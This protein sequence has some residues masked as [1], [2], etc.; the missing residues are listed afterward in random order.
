MTTQTSATKAGG[1]SALLA[2]LS[3]KAPPPEPVVKQD[4]LSVILSV[5]TNRAP[6]ADPGPA[7]QR[8][9]EKPLLP[10]AGAG[11]DATADATAASL[12]LCLLAPPLPLPPQ[13]PLL[14][15]AAAH[16]SLPVPSAPR[17]Q[18]A[19]Q[20]K[21]AKTDAAEKEPALATHLSP[22]D[23]APEKKPA[24]AA[25]EKAP[26]LAAQL[27]PANAAPEKKPAEAA[28]E[29]AP[30][31]AA[32]LSPA[33]AAP[34]KKPTQPV[35]DRALPLPARP[36]PAEVAAAKSAPSSGT[37]VALRSQRMN[38]MS[39]RDEIAGPTEQN[40]PGADLSAISGANAGG[41]SQD[42]AK[43][44]LAFSWQETASEEVAVAVLSAKA[45]GQ[46]APSTEAAPSEPPVSAPLDR[47][48][49]MI[50][51]QVVDFR[52]AGAQS[53]GVTLKVDAQTQLFLQLTT[54]N[55]QVR[56]S[57]RCDRGS[58][59]P[60]ESQWAQLQQSLARQNVQLLPLDGALR[61]GF[62]Q[63]PDNP[64]RHLASGS[65]NGPPAGAA[66]EPAQPR[67]QRGQNRSPKNWESWA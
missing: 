64:Q 12:L 36:P 10:P 61:P 27:S 50:F 6:K 23:T 35:T 48:E 40:L 38:Y 15:K 25:A 32:Q 13:L 66:V 42:R 59:S 31:L 16:Q 44:P 3:P 24:E 58:F 45:A 9:N 49:Q 60:P 46:A 1:L 11:D 43:S 20:T 54:S 52:Q 4:F 53:L 2:S 67:K 17:A 55:G 22:A 37:S 5:L 63:S 18:T 62:E 39:E 34:E 41:G 30:A 14:A 33:N 8:P 28:A 19:A 56:A 51:R 7:A 21:P 57:V 65:Q 29:K 26:A 47:L